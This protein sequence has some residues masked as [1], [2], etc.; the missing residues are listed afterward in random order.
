MQV[1]PHRCPALLAALSP[2]N[3]HSPNSMS[4]VAQHPG[5]GTGSTAQLAAPLTVLVP[6]S[7]EIRAEVNTFLAGLPLGTSRRDKTVEDAVARQL[8]SLLNTRAD[9][10]LKLNQ[11][12]S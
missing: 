4:V 5:A 2:D 7:L 6:S 9:L 3:S 1:L 8:Y 10:Q 11:W 12:C